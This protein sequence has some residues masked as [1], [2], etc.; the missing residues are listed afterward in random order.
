MA[1]LDKQDHP[2]LFLPLIVS[3]PNP[4]ACTNIS[5]ETCQ[6]QPDGSRIG[7]I[8]IILLLFKEY[9]GCLLRPGCI[10]PTPGTA[11]TL[12]LADP[13]CPTRHTNRN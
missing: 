4:I 1:K 11:T 9:P 13:K 3:I 7:I 8:I 5:R 12:I 6:C 2:V 10:F